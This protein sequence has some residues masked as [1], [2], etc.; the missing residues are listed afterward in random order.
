M[1]SQRSLCLHFASDAF[2]IRIL[3]DE[4]STVVDWYQLGM[5]LGVLDHMLDEI[6]RNHPH[7][8]VS[9]WRV[10]VLS[11]WLKL[12]PDASWRNVVRA[13]QRMGE[14]ALAEKIRH[15]YIRRAQSRLC[16]T[17]LSI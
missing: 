13:L 12:T 3:S 4:L 11:L 10:E 6:Q 17:I 8:G 9:R 7:E 1:Y 5:K 15:K 16:C 2:C 14:N